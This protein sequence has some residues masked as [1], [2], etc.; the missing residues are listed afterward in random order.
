MLLRTDTVVEAG[1]ISEDLD[2]PI[3]RLVMCVTMQVMHYHSGLEDAASQFIIKACI[4]R[5]V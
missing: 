4:C 2:N 3:T 5:C 1:E